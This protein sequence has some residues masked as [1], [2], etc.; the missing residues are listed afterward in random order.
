VPAPVV[1]SPPALPPP[2]ALLLGS[3]LERVVSDGFEHGLGAW[4]RRTG[5]VVA[6]SDAA[7]SGRRGLRATLVRGAPSFVQRRLPHAGSRAEL[8]FELDPRSL[9]SGGA[10]IEIAAI[11]SASG[12][13]LASVDLRSLG[14]GHQIRLSAGTGTGARATVRSQRRPVRRRPTVVVLSLDPAQAVL[15]VDGVELG[16]LAR[17][18]SS[19]LPAGIV[20]GP[21]RGGP[22]ASTGYLDIDGVTVREAPATS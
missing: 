9:S 7:M 15:A 20:L 11:T 17:A 16:R 12:Q 8:A 5:R 2:P 22:A 19:P 1:P 6:T 14:G 10:W 18:P 13:R 4:P 21:W 3:S